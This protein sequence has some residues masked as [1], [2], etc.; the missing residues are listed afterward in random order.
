MLRRSLEFL[1]S[2]LF[3]VFVAT[4]QAPAS[5]D[6]CG[7]P[8]VD[9]DGDGIQ[10][11]DEDLE[12]SGNCDDTDTDGDGFPNYLDIDDDAD[13]IPTLVEGIAETD[14]D[15]VPNYLDIDSDGDD[16][17]DT[18][19]A[20]DD[21]SDGQADVTASGNDTDGDGLDDSFDTDDGGTQPPLT[22]HDD[23]GI[24]S[25]LDPDDDNDG[26]PTIVE[27]NGD[28]DGDGIPDYLDVDP[29]TA[30]PSEPREDPRRTWLRIDN[31]IESGTLLFHFR[32]PSGALKLKILNVR[33]RQAST[34]LQTWHP[35][36]EDTFG[37]NVSSLP[38]GVYFVRIE[39]SR[40]HATSQFVRVR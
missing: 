39:S 10:D 24:P 35:G 4:L 18:I 36:G 21:N 6:S 27:G 34:V 25:Y 38:S 3:I 17:L 16:I 22:D 37:W 15:F 28:A 13:G 7:P 1:T 2:A 32:A 40:G 26:I 30:V 5:A 9:S 12:G 29:V 14:G 11:I 31:T 19:E 8:G 20:Q 23:D 33:G